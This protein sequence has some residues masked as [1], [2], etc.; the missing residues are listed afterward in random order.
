MKYR[1]SQPKQF[2][3]KTENTDYIN[4][5]DQITKHPQDNPIELPLLQGK[6]PR[7]LS[8]NT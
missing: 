3:N 6:L 4:S 2:Y 5:H 1:K 7:A 8:I